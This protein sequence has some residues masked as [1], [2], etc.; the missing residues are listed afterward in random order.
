M[1]SEVISPEVKQSFTWSTPFFDVTFV[2]IKSKKGKCLVFRLSILGINFIITVQFP[3]ANGPDGLML[4]HH[5]CGIGCVIPEMR[6]LPVPTH[7]DKS[8]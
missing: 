1:E 7:L 6:A 8:V 2:D 5:H 4:Y 3:T